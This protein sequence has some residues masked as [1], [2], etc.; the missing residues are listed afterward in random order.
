MSN[1]YR[2]I[3]FK[4]FELIL[5]E[6]KFKKTIDSVDSISTERSLETILQQI[7]TNK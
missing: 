3:S 6:S 1:I 5:I 4:S 2:F 7:I